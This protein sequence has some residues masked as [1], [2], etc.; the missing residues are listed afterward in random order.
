MAVKCGA[1]GADNEGWIPK[2]RLDKVSEQ[3]RNLRDELANA[4]QA[5]D[6]LRSETST[7]S[8]E[9]AAKLS[10]AELEAERS[11]WATERA[12]MAAGVTDEEGVGIARLLWDRMA[13][14]DRPA[15]VGDWLKSDSVPLA[16]R[17]YLPTT[18][19]EAPTTTTE[20]EAPAT[21]GERVNRNPPTNRGATAAAPTAPVYSREAIANMTPAEY[22]EHRQ[23]IR[24][25][26]KAGR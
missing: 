2:E 1:C 16:I 17:A 4:Q 26:M 13:E 5:L 14:D 3:R 23:Q 22:R 10:V 18:T 8:A 9:V 21:N 15:S 11:G 6:D 24:A 7:A 19:T 20:A 12:L 25:D